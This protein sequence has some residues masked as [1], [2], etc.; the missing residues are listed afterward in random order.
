[1]SKLITFSLQHDRL[2]FG[3]FP[4]DELNELDG[5]TVTVAPISTFTDIVTFTLNDDEDKHQAL[6]VL[7]MYTQ[8]LISKRMKINQN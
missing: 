4:A 5:I 8:S 1:M 3:P 6:F 7:G 2:I